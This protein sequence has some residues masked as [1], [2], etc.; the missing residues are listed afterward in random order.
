M[1]TPLLKNISFEKLFSWVLDYKFLKHFGCAC[2]PNLRPY[3]SHKFSLQSKQCVFLGYSSHHKG[4]K[5]Y[6]LESGRMYVSRDVVFHEDVFPFLQTSSKSIQSP[7]SSPT[8]SSLSRPINNM[9]VSVPTLPSP[10]PSPSSLNTNSNNTHSPI[11]SSSTHVEPDVTIVQALDTAPPRLHPMQTRSHNNVRQIR[12]LTNG[13]VRYPLPRAL[14]SKAALLEPTCFSNSV[15]VSEW[16][17][18]MQVEF[19]ALLK[20]CTWSLVPPQAAKN[21]VGCKWVFKLKRKADGS[22]ERHK[23]RL[24]AKG[25]H[26]HAGLDYGETFS[27]VVKPT[28]IRTVLSIAYSAG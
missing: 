18:A 23:A 21:V 4:Y 5:C 3:N 26:Q 14:L 1:P 17:N 20:N 6:H 2:F 16:L 19:N 27:L 8:S 10:S 15:K 11:S 24:V 13:R 9:S 12:Q 7:S 28:T 25:F 22:V